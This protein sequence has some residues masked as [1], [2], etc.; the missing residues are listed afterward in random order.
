MNYPNHII[1]VMLN[2]EYL[3]LFWLY[4]PL[5]HPLDHN[6]IVLLLILTVHHIGLMEHNQSL[7]GR[8]IVV[9]GTLHICILAFAYLVTYILVAVWCQIEVVQ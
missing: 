3:L 1:Y 4:L 2:D 9:L 8:C 7:L 5:L 6:S